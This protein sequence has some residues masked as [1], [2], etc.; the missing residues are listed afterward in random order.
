MSLIE[1][2]IATAIIS[3]CLI[4]LL[5]LFPIM[6]DTVGG[7]RERALSYRIYQIVSA[8]LRSTPPTPA[9]SSLSYHFDGDAFPAESDNEQYQATVELSLSSNLPPSS[10]NQSLIHARIAVKNTNT[11]RTTLQRTIWI[12][13]YD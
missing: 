3:F 9:S 10:T 1:V 6:L 5:G 8:E 12:V 2:A 11:E 13:K 4:A 7:S